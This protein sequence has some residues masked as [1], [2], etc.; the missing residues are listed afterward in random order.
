[1]AFLPHGRGGRRAATYLCLLQEGVQVSQ[2]QGTVDS[3]EVSAYRRIS[4]VVDGSIVT[5]LYPG[6]AISFRVAIGRDADDGECIEIV[7]D[8]AQAQVML[9]AWHRSGA[10]G[11]TTVLPATPCQV[12]VQRPRRAVDR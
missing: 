2:H 6:G 5:S 7:L 12:G 11:S 8:G 9:E 1:M 3:V 10:S 4:G